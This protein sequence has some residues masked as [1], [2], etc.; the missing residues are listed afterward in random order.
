MSRR[1][2]LSATKVV[3][4]PCAEFILAAPSPSSTRPALLRHE[5]LSLA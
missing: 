3:S 4:D 5:T 2:S 1:L